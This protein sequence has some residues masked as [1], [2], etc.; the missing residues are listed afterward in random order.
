MLLT[1][2]KIKEQN[3]TK[4]TFLIS[5]AKR[6]HVI[7]T[8]DTVIGDDISRPIDDESLLCCFIR[9]KI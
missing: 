1:W 6:Y 9:K 4:H 8:F 5:V 7:S 3:T 2:E